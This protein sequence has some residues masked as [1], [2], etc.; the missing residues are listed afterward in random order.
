M[1]DTAHPNDIDIMLSNM[2]NRLS[3]GELIDF[4]EWEELEDM[5]AN[6]DSGEILREKGL[7][8]KP[9]LKQAIKHREDFRKRLKQF[10]LPFA[11]RYEL[12]KQLY[13]LAKKEPSVELLRIFCEINC[14]YNFF[15]TVHDNNDVHDEDLAVSRVNQKE[16]TEA[17][18]S[19]LYAR[20]MLSKR[21]PV[22]LEQ[23][24]T[25]RVPQ[26]SKV[27]GESERQCRIFAAYDNIFN[28]K[29]EEAHFMDNIACLLQVADMSEP[30]SQV[31]PLFLFNVL[32]KHGK[33]LQK[34]D[35]LLIDGKALWKPQNYNIKKDNGKNYSAYTNY[36]SLFYELCHIFQDDEQVDIPLCIYAFDHLSNLGKFARSI[37]FP[38]SSDL[39]DEFQEFV[40]DRSLFDIVHN[41]IFICYEDENAANVIIAE[42]DITPDDVLN[43]QTNQEPRH[44]RA[45]KRLEDY[46]NS[47]ASELTDRFLKVEGQAESV[48]DL[49]VDILESAKLPATYQPKNM[50]ETIL[51]LAM[52]NAALLE[53]VTFFAAD[54][55]VRAGNLLVGNKEDFLLD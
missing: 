21:F 17:L 51:Y 8:A 31:K 50:D 22:L 1:Y 35:D 33:R 48:R 39:S 55:F 13:E 6:E 29:S 54:Y 36:L 43:M 12:C 32:I 10:G 53:A 15:L 7:K 26:L 16:A 3:R 37:D 14:D 42:N 19:E 5:I 18:Y 40:F 24:K 28:I 34:S 4:M 27:P 9:V 11:N 49:C 20:L 41:F 25:V 52:I 45:K 44:V 38:S 2:S 47:Y 30:L 46:M 23:L